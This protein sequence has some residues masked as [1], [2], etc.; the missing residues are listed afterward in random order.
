MVVTGE[1]AQP[2][3]P[4]TWSRYTYGIGNPPQTVNPCALSPSHSVANVSH[5]SAARRDGSDRPERQRVTIGRR[6]R[7]IRGGKRV[8]CLSVSEITSY[9]YG[10]RRAVLLGATW[11][12]S[13]PRLASGS[14][15][16]GIGDHAVGAR[17]LPARPNFPTR[18]TQIKLK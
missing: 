13:P 18:P 10:S 2:R 11:A 9:V 8:G 5:P 17:L 7:E 6:A 14:V 12:K 4:S 16:E 3:R 1:L 15:R